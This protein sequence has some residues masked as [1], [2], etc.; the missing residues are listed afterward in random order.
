MMI[1]AIAMNDFRILVYIFLTNQS[2][3][4]LYARTF[5]SLAHATNPL[6]TL[7]PLSSFAPY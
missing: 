6:P 5:S 1:V 3:L 2:F 7:E 4:S